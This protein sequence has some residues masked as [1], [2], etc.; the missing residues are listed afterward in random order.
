MLFPEVERDVRV[1]NR[2]MSHF[3][4]LT[5]CYRPEC[6]SIRN[7][8][9]NW[10]RHYP[11]S[12]KK[13]LKAR[14]A[15]DKINYYSAF[16]ELYLYE[17]LRR[18]GYSIQVHPTLPTIETTQP[19]FLAT[20][21]TGEEVIIEAVAVSEQSGEDPATTN[22]RETV[23]DTIDRLDHPYFYVLLN[24]KGSPTASPSGRKIR[25]SLKRWLDSLDYNTCHTLLESNRFTDLP[26]QAFNENGWILE[27]QA[28]PKPKNQLGKP[29]ERLIHLHMPEVHWIDSR[30]PIRDA[31]R[32]KASKYGD[33]QRPYLVAVNAMGHF[34][35]EIAIFEALFG[36]EVMIFGAE[37]EVKS[38][39][40]R[41]PDGAWTSEQGERNTR[42][43]GVLIGQSVFPNNVADTSV[44]LYHNPWAKR[45]YIG[46]LSS[47][48][49]FV[50]S[51]G[52]MKKVDGMLPRSIFGLDENWLQAGA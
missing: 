44:V 15:S 33:I 10:F 49:Q 4:F 51:E 35:D 30:T 38:R 29:N 26:T 34:V 2:A 39:M 45:E 40:A 43:S 24:E 14:L 19:D 21:P 31:I 13:E 46:L 25:A 20:S 32:R 16:W 22:R 37:P 5:R 52:G 42:I 17:L 27:F 9:E 41:R 8:W 47:L 7:L 23:L 3:E 1:A 18:L 28:F 50:P 6:E 12:E 36:T 48:K 11:D